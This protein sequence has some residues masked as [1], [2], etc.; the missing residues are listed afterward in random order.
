MTSASDEAAV[1]AL[2]DELIDTTTGLRLPADANFF[3]AGID[4]QT[5]VRLHAA[6]EGRLAREVPLTD[7]FKY[8]NRRTLARHLVHPTA[9]E[10]AAAAVRPA[11]PAPTGGAPRAHDRRTLRTRIRAR[12]D[13]RTRDGGHA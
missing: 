10:P 6:L 4:S 5:L 2:L 1:R 9:G 8:P 3:E 13:L 7:L 11:D 12:T